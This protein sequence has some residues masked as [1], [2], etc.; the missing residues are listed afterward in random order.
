MGDLILQKVDEIP[1]NAVEV[2]LERLPG[3]RVHLGDGYYIGGDPQ[4]RD[5]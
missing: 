3:G 4:L 1:P 2:E 5:Q